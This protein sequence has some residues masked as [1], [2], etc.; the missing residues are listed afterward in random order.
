MLPFGW[1]LEFVSLL[2]R[3]KFDTTEIIGRYENRM[4]TSV[5]ADLVMMGQDKVGSYALSATKKDLFAASLGAYLDIISSV[6]NTQLTPVLW[7][8][9]GFKGDPPRLCHGTIETID[10]QTIGTFINMIGRVGALIDRE[11]AL[12][13]LNDQA[14]CPRLMIPRPATSRRSLGGVDMGSTGGDLGCCSDTPPPGSL[15]N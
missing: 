11:T 8:L 7:D 1:T 3:D 4:A 13:F 10:L 12:P 2:Q 9:N 6:I 14:G 5:L 15:Y